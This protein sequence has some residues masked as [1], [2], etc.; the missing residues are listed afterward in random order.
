MIKKLFI[1]LCTFSCM[2]LVLSV[3]ACSNDEESY[4][5]TT[6]N[7]PL[8]DVIVK[9]MK[10]SAASSEEVYVIFSSSDDFSILDRST[11]MLTQFISTATQSTEESTFVLD[12]KNGTARTIQGMDMAEP[13]GDW[14]YAGRTTDKT[15][16]IVKFATK[17]GKTLPKNREYI[18]RIVPV[19]NE[20]K[21]VIGYDVYYQ[22]V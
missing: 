12:T 16:D 13:A 5:Q 10:Q 11:Y 14:I 9:A 3:T 22:I 20:E 18:L 1:A 21:E 4:E 19:L 2:T 17:L 6:E 8:A 15:F 7:N